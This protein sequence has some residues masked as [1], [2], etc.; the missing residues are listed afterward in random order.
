VTVADVAVWS[1][2]FPLATGTKLQQ[3]LLSEQT[4][5]QHWFAHLS[6]QPQVKVWWWHFN[7]IYWLWN[8]F[9]WHWKVFISRQVVAVVTFKL[10][11]GCCTRFLTSFMLQISVC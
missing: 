10:W 3:E 8:V 2:L 4:Y 9:C 6:V 5:V 11:S 1:I 7:F